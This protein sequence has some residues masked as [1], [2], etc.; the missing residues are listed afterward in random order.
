MAKQSG[1]R[2]HASKLFGGPHKTHD[3]EIMESMRYAGLIQRALLPS[4]HQLKKLLDQYFILFMPKSIVSGDFY[5][6]TQKDRQ[7]YIVV[8]DCTGHGVPGALMSILG[9]SFL[10]EIIKNGTSTTAGRILNKLREKVMEALNQTGNFNE[11]K[12]GMDI[13][14]CIFNYD[15]S[16][17]QFAGANN[18]VYIIRDNV[19]QETIPDKMPVGIN[20]IHEEPFSS[21]EIDIFRNDVIYMFSDGFADQ[22][23]GPESRK[24]KYGPFRQLLLDIYKKDMDDQQL[25][26]RQTIEDWMG[27]NEQVDDIL[28]MGFKIL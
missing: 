15:K 9:I 13:S 17:M 20:A 23:G 8:A 22:F 6:I 4:D 19:I 21:H 25:I 26:L 18:P 5:W 11:S 12:D 16:R 3:R 24:F 14:L 1:Y 2:K 7:T 27:Q 10:N 28:V